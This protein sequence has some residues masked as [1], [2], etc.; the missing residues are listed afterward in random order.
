MNCVD[1]ESIVSLA[2]SAILS[3]SLE[4]IEL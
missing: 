2:R 1:D 3:L 4:Y